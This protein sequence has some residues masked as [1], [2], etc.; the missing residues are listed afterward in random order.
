MGPGVIRKYRCSVCFG[1]KKHRRSMKNRE[2]LKLIFCNVFFCCYSDT[3][4]QRLTL[5]ILIKRRWCIYFEFRS[6]ME[7]TDNITLHFS[8][9]KTIYR[10]FS[11]C[12]Y[13]QLQFPCTPLHIN[14]SYCSIFSKLISATY[15]N[16]MVYFSI[17]CFSQNVDVVDMVTASLE[18]MLNWGVVLSNQ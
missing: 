11:G 10:I 2:A 17:K 5:H 18:L 1:F 16:V 12:L 15:M 9:T 4:S 13:W 3:C 6:G 8:A 7:S 14:P